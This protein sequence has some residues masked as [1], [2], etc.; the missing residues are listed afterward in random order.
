MINLH[1][2]DVGRLTSRANRTRDVDVRV[3]HI[4]EPSV[5]W[6]GDR[7]IRETDFHRPLTDVARQ[8]RCDVSF[9]AET[10][11]NRTIRARTPNVEVDTTG[12]TDVRI[13]LQDRLV[14]EDGAIG[15]KI[16]R[17]SLA[18]DDGLRST[19]GLA[20]HECVQEN[21]HDRQSNREQQ[22]DATLAHVLRMALHRFFLPFVFLRFLRC[23]SETLLAND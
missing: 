6:V 15:A 9:V 7:V 1:E 4:L 13:A 20:H 10:L 23:F 2:H 18:R 16:L 22:G 11:S 21:T 19:R 8:A 14:V 17:Q 3:E 12:Q 5:R